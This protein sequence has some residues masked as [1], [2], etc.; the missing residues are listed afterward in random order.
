[1]NRA[2][3]IGPVVL[4]LALLAGRAGQ[5]GQVQTD[6]NLITGLDISD[7]ISSEERLLQLKGMAE[8]IRAPA[9][10]EAIQRGRHGCVGFAMFDWY[11][12]TFPVVVPW[13]AVCTAR[14]AAGVSDRIS[15]RLSVNIELEARQAWTFYPGRP[16]DLS[17]AL[18]HAAQEL[19][20]APFATTRT[21]INIIGNGAD[22]VGEGPV[23]VRDQ[24][25]GQGGII[26]GIVI[27]ADKETVDYYR[28]EVIGGANAFVLSIEQPGDAVDI[29]VRKL[30]GD[31]VAAVPR[32]ASP[33]PG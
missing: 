10:L 21:I 14:D 3:T 1:M 28:R 20:A 8:A 13:T 7:S 29:L 27:G 32:G 15:A 16:T 19:H 6:A 26:N 18:E 24:I 5:A 31:I 12:S 17:E 11:H 2:A 9:V 4:A 25:V 30:L 23:S 22:N 33:P